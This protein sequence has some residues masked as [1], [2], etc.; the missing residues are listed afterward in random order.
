[1]RRAGGGGWGSGRGARRGGR[2]GSGKGF[3][4][5][6]C[7]SVAAKSARGRSALLSHPCADESGERKGSRSIGRRVSGLRVNE[8]N[9]SGEKKKGGGGETSEGVRGR[10]STNKEKLLEHNQKAASGAMF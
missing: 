3:T 6:T 8:Q 2:G 5:A 1:M 9:H 4:S 7:G 10:P